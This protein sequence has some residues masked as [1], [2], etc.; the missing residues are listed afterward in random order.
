MNPRRGI[1]R[2]WGVFLALLALA[3]GVITL[4]HRWHRVFPSSEVSGVYAHY[5]NVGGID[6]SFVKKYRINDTMFVDVTM[7]QA[8]TDSAWNK[9]KEDFHV[10]ALSD[11]MLK[12]M[13]TGSPCL[14]FCKL[15]D[16]LQRSA[17]SNKYTI[18][19]ADYREHAIAVL[20]SKTKEQKDAII[21]S[22]F[23]KYFLNIKQ[24]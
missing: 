6:A 17:D 8:K 1:L 5:E 3:L 20:F 7:L 22:Y 15:P 12:A 4:I 11:E 18:A 19:V 21:E 23:E 24:Q 9:L 13:N 2:F 16:T 14:A 10:P